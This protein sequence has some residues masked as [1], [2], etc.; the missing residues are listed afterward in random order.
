[1]KS[2][3]VIR[4]IDELGRIVIPKEI[5]KALNIKEYDDIEFTVQENQILLSKYSKLLN[6]KKASDDL[7]STLSDLTDCSIYITDKDKVITT[8]DLENKYISN[9]LSTLLSERKAYLSEVVESMAFDTST[10]D[11]YF[12]I[13]PIIRDSD[14]IGLVIVYKKE[15]LS[16][17]DKMLS[18]VIKKLIENK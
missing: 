7:V 18:L 4:K 16:N 8:G 9:K 3:G 6:Q 1:M 11:G 5:R 15:K 17:E 14:V 2:T 12:C 13:E 10:K